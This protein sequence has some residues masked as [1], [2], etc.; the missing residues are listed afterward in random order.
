MRLERRRGEQRDLLSFL[1]ATR[2]L[3]IVEIGRPKLHETRL[4]RLAFFHEHEA[5]ARTTRA[6]GSHFA[7]ATDVEC[8][9]LRVRSAT[10]ARA[11][12][13]AALLST[14]RLAALRL[15]ADCWCTAA[16]SA[17]AAGLHLL[18]AACARN[19]CIDADRG[20]DPGGLGPHRIPIHRAT[21]HLLA[22][23]VE[24]RF[25]GRV[26]RE[27][28]RD[29]LAFLLGDVNLL[30]TTLTTLSLP[31]IERDVA[32][33]SSARVSSPARTRRA[34]AATRA[35]AATR[36]H[37][38]GDLRTDGIRVQSEDGRRGRRFTRIA[39]GVI[40]NR[41]HARALLDHHVRLAV[42]AGLEQAF[43]ILQRDEHGEHRD[44]LLDHG[45]RLDLFHEAG[46]PAIGIR[47]HRD[48]GGLA[49]TN[50]PDVR[51]VEQCADSHLAQV[52]HLEQ[53]R[54][55]TERTGRGRDDGA[56]RHGSLDDRTAHRRR[57]RR[58][59]KALFRQV[60]GRGRGDEL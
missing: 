42:H 25:L 13:T 29:R 53:R 60:H 27:R 5:R 33:R 46:E 14:S 38:C 55:A 26:L 9:T 3:R 17:A 6:R 37:L 40:R 28:R 10:R 7:S 8:G 18:A 58:V 52:G 35:S 54:A 43:A 12:A 22:Q 50:L 49:W 36:S 19:P 44:V 47:V 2:D 31:G 24:L 34:A 45:L 32:V 48:R 56:E 20:V 39:H 11:V 23:A 59:L 21:H 51:L 30:E 41:E 1:Q 15:S 16:L 4:E 57:H